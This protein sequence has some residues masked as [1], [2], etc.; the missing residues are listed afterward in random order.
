[1]QGSTG[2]GWT[3]IWLVTFSFMAF[4]NLKIDIL[5]QFEKRPIL[6]NASTILL[7]SLS[8]VGADRFDEPKLLS[9]KA[10]KRLRT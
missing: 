7:V 9:N 6:S 10:K 2:A 8:A 5:I 4:R 3:D 1:M